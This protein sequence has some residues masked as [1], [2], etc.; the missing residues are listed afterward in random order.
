MM[1]GGGVMLMVCCCVVY[2][3]W[4]LASAGVVTLGTGLSAMC[5]DLATTR[6]KYAN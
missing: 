5:V 6:R 3:S 1:T 2:D 4:W